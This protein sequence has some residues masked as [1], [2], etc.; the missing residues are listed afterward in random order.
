MRRARTIATAL[1]GSLAIGLTACSASVTAPPARPATVELAAPAASPVGSTIVELRNVAFSPARVLV[2]RGTTVTFA[3]R[4]GD[5]PH[6]VTSV[7]RRRFRRLGPRKS[8]TATVRFTHRGTF[9]YVCTI[10]PGM[11][12]R[13]VVR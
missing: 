7:G 12:G 6:D 9:R 5:T 1:G 10:H 11:A 8:G 4:D 13:V 3:W 2:R